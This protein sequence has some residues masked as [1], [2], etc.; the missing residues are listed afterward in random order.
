MTVLPRRLL[1]AF[2]CLFVSLALALAALVWFLSPVTVRA[3]DHPGICPVSSGQLRAVVDHSH[4]EI[5]QLSAMQMGLYF[6]AAWGGSFSWQWP[7]GV[8]ASWPR[9]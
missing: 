1:A 9:S 8:V 5:T 3:Q 4:G 7:P 6:R 2:L